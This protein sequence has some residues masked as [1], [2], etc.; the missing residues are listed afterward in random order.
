MDMMGWAVSEAHRLGMGVDMTTGTGWCFGGPQVTDND[1][2][3]S[4]VVKTYVIVSGQ[5]V[6]GKFSRDATQAL[7]AFSSD[8]KSVELTDKISASGELD[9][10]VPNDS[11]NWTIYAISQKPSGQKVKRA[12]PGGE[13]WM[14]NLIYPPAMDDFLKPYTAAF[15]SYHGPKPRAQ[16]VDSYEYRSDWSPNFFAEFE[17]RRGYKLQTELPALFSKNP[18]DHRARVLCDYRQTVSEIMA[19]ESMPA[20]TKWA[21]A[22]GFITRSARPAICWIFTP[23]PTF[24]KP[25]CS[26]L[27]ATS[28]SPNSRRPPRTSR[29]IRSSAPRPAPGWKNIS[30]RNCPT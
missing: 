9:W 24:R 10:T 30:P 16:F 6:N 14:L 17:K 12:A 7:V 21:H 5:K 19:E 29:A 2:N 23:P 26:T 11:T 1:A 8:G 15:A 3:A 13:G 22:E 20:W 25:R 18:D 28:W 27:T 4:V